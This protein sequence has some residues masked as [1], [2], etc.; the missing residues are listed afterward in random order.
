[1]V[2][3]TKKAVYPVYSYLVFVA[4]CASLTLARH[5]YVKT[6]LYMALAALPV[7]IAALVWVCL[8]KVRGPRNPRR[9]SCLRSLLASA[10]ASSRC[11]HTR[12]RPCPTARG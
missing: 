8:P 1:M 11:Q 4:F 5:I 3:V 12:V 7:H 9:L 6:G 10:S 2:T